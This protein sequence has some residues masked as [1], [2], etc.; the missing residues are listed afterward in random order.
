VDFYCPRAVFNPRSLVP[1]V[2]T[3]AITPLRMTKTFGN[4]Y[5]ECLYLVR[6]NLEMEGNKNM[7]HNLDL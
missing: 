2:S 1:V 5:G 3:L 4:N 7:S 6:M